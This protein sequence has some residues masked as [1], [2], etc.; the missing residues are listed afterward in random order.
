MGAIMS[1]RCRYQREFS[2]LL[3]TFA[4]ELRAAGMDPASLRCHSRLHTAPPDH[5]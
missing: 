3:V 1:D 2:I 4:N 5:L